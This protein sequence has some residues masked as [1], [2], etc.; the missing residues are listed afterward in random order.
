[1]MSLARIAAKQSPPK[2]RMRSGKRGIVGRELQVR[3]V[4]D[5]QLLDVAEAEQRSRWNTWTVWVD[6]I[7]SWSN[8]KSRNSAGIAR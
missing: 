2:S 3:P 6:W 1:M 4:V 8:R 7:S 5:D